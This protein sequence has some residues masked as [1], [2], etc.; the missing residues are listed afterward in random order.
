MGYKSEQIMAI[1]RSNFL[2]HDYPYYSKAIIHPRRSVNQDD[3]E[4][5]RVKL[6]MDFKI[7]LEGHFGKQPKRCLKSLEVRNYSKS[8]PELCIPSDITEQSL[9]PRSAT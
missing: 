7:M 3:L 4:K 1:S 8:L 6:I 9:L 2:S 5:F